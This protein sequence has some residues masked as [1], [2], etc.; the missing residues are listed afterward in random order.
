MNRLNKKGKITAEAQAAFGRALA[1]DPKEP[2]ARLF[3]AMGLIQQGKTTE[4][5]S[6]LEVQLAAAPPNAPWRPAIE[7]ALASLEKPIAGKIAKGPTQ[8]EA[9]AAAQMSGEDRLAMIE[10]MVAGLA[11]KVKQNPD[12]VSDWQKLI[13]SYVV[14]GKKDDALKALGDAQIAFK[15]DLAKQGEIS[16]FAKELGLTGS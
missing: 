7:N 4:A 13:R 6:A 12:N 15:Q 5:K 11:A 2:K 8:E 9:D 14:L 3:L 10:S 1:L 16:D